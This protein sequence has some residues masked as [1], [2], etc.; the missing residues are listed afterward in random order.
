MLKKDWRKERDETESEQPEPVVSKTEP[1]GIA[2]IFPLFLDT[3]LMKCT[4]K[5][6]HYSQNLQELHQNKLQGWQ[7]SHLNRITHQNIALERR[8]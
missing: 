6:S 7:G 1:L 3:A 5:Y 2:D 8:Y 4:W